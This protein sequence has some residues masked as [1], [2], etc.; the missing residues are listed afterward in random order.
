MLLPP[1]DE[2]D[3]ELEIVNCPAAPLVP[4][5]IES[6]EPEESVITLAVT[7]IAAELILEARDAR[8]VSLSPL[9]TLKVV[10]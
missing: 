8:V 5:T 10:P 3:K 2:S 1:E 6:R 4:L 7:P 9:S